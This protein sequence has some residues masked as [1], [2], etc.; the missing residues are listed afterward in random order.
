MIC[1][2]RRRKKLRKTMSVT[3]F[4]FYRGTFTILFMCISC[5]FLSYI[6]GI[7]GLKQ[8][9]IERQ[10][11]ILEEQV[12]GSQMF[13]WDRV[14]TLFSIAFATLE[15]AFNIIFVVMSKSHVSFLFSWCT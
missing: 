13:V 4:S 11:Q 8:G 3:D 14:T 2:R 10:R 5:P 15:Y 12:R 9:M 1:M 7:S 6:N